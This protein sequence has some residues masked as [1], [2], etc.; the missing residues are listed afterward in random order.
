MNTG[1]HRVLSLLNT[2]GF[3]GFLRFLGLSGFLGSLAYLVRRGKSRLTIWCPPR[4]RPTEQEKPANKSLNSVLIE[5][6]FPRPD[7]LLHRRRRSGQLLTPRRP[8]DSS[9]P[10]L[11]LNTWNRSMN[12]RPP[13]KTLSLRQSI[14]CSLARPLSSTRRWSCPTVCRSLRTRAFR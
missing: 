3:V 10:V 14:A 1:A 12:L 9:Y 4:K 7:T 5:A 11:C 13:L 2:R 6:V 8:Q